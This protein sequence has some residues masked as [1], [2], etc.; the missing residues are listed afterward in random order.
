MCV[1]DVFDSEAVSMPVEGI[2][3]WRR[4][5]RSSSCAG[6][7]TAAI[8]VS[9]ASL[10]VQIVCTTTHQHTAGADKCVKY[11]GKVKREE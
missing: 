2:S 10:G 3:I 11:A 1:G 4:K 5:P 6:Q 7:C 9:R 8:I